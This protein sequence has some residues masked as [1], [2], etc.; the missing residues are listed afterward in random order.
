M[1]FMMVDFRRRSSC[2]QYF[3]WFF[4]ANILYFQIQFNIFEYSIHVC[5]H[6]WRDS[7]FLI[8]GTCVILVSDFIF[9]FCDITIIMTSSSQ[10]SRLE[11]SYSLDSL[12]RFRSRNRNSL[13]RISQL[14]KQQ[15]Q[16]Y[17]NISFFWI[18]NYFNFIRNFE[19]IW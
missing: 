6:A 11:Q 9:K 17:V 18:D 7:L 14:T 19:I 12:Y 13:K 3:Q 4:D 16:Q 5:I 8:P 2:K 1:I 10:N 15:P